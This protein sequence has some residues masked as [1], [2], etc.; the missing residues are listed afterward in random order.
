M[1]QA[2][3][4][5]F[6]SPRGPSGNATG[7]CNGPHAPRPDVEPSAQPPDIAEAEVAFSA[8]GM[9]TEATA[10]AESAA[11]AESAVDPESAAN[12]EPATGEPA[13]DSEPAAPAGSCAATEGS[14]EEAPPP[15][16][17]SCLEAPD[18]SGLRLDNMDFYQLL[19]VSKDAAAEVIKKG[20]KEQ[21]RAW[22][23]DKA[24]PQA[25]EYFQV[26]SQAHAV[27]TDEYTRS[28]YDALLERFPPL[29]PT[30]AEMHGAHFQD[31]EPFQASIA[32]LTAVAT[33]PFDS[34]CGH[35]LL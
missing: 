1:P 9:E 30:F 31:M 7:A 3:F 18:G 25:K 14:P 32:D 29:R 33:F 21:A 2:S 12:A 23:P 28:I 5:L 26:L 10:D 6:S 15:R 27:L 20:F 16:L 8:Q 34:E 13:T 24:G 11:N 4:L 35:Q 19:G 22:H 17:P